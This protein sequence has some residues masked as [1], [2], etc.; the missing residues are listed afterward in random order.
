L[1]AQPISLS[2]NFGENTVSFGKTYTTCRSV[3][4]DR[5]SNEYWSQVI[6]M[7][8]MLHDI[9][10]GPWSHTF[11]T[12]NLPQDFSSVISKLSGGVRRYFDDLLSRKQ[13]LMHEDISVLYISQ[14]LRT[15]KPRAP[16]PTPGNTSW[17]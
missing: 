17:R 7:A 13:S 11:E 12:L 2:R 3:A 4:E 16:C 10:H 15:S 14:I 6:C 1:G 5:A 9:G 8:G